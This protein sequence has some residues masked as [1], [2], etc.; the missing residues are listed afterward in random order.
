MHCDVKMPEKLGKI[1]FIH[2]AH[3]HWFLKLLTSAFAYLPW[4]L[5]ISL[6]TQSCKTKMFQNLQWGLDFDLQLPH[7]DCLPISLKTLLQLLV[8]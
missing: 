4:H 5:T 3:I 6:I 1:C 7:E 8:Y 2:K